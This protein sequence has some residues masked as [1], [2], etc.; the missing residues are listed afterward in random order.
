MKMRN[1]SEQ[2]KCFG[3]DLK[4]VKVVVT[5]SVRR[6]TDKIINFVKNVKKIPKSHSNESK[7]SELNKNEWSV[8]NVLSASYV[9]RENMILLPM[10]KVI[11]EKQECGF[12]G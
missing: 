4:M 3:K 6:K 1:E 9:N 11:N 2:I 10:N 8:P 7:T 12:V 5:K